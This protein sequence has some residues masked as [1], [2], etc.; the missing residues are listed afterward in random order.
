MHFCNS[1]GTYRYT[2]PNL[3][4]V[5]TRRGRGRETPDGR[6]GDRARRIVD[7]ARSACAHL[8]NPREEARRDGGLSAFR[9]EQDFGPPLSFAACQRGSVAALHKVRVWESYRSGPTD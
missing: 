4:E 9:S 3:L 8:D 6:R 1:Q 7:G 5:K 2:M